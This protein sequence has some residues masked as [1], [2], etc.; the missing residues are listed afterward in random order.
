MASRSGSVH[1]PLEG[2]GRSRA[3][4]A[5]WVISQHGD[6]PWGEITPPRL[7]FRCAPCEPTLPLQGRVRK[8]GSKATRSPHWRFVSIV[9][10]LP[11]RGCDVRQEPYIPGALS[12]L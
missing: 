2:E 6:C 4:R 5:G 3:A 12:I 8:R 11:K 7:T 1:P 10:T 9:V